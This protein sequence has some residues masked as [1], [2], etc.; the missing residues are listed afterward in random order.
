[1][2][3]LWSAWRHLRKHA[4]HHAHSCPRRYR[5]YT[6]SSYGGGGGTLCST[7]E[8]G[9]GGRRRTVARAA[10]SLRMI[11]IILHLRGARKLKCAWVIKLDK[12]QDG[13][14][15]RGGRPPASKGGTWSVWLSLRLLYDESSPE[16]PSPVDVY[17]ESSP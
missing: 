6:R 16:D 4:G 3:G 12:Q 14:A 11:F 8:A 17:D 5:G 10:A 7:A 15:L 2:G 13:A 9:I 1:V